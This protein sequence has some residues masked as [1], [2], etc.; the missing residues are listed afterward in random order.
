MSYKTRAEAIEAGFD[1]LKKM[2]GEGWDLEV[3]DN[4]GWHF[5]LRSGPVAVYEC[6]GPGTYHCLVSDN[7]KG[8]AGGAGHWTGDH[9]SRKDPNQAAKDGVMDMVKKVEQYN[10]AREAGLRAIGGKAK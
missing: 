2:K 6:V 9:P 8:G 1:C 10:K 4:I 3:W 5:C 7:P